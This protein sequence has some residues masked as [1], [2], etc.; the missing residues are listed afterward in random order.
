MYKRDIYTICEN[1]KI[2]NAVFLMTLKGDTSFLTAPGQFINIELDGFY[3]RR[4][5]SV[6]DW[7]KEIITIIYK[8]VGGGTQKLS[9]MHCGESLDVLTGLGN[10]FT[11]SS[12]S[13]APLVIGGGV[14]APPMYALAKQLVA[15]GKIPTVILGFASKEDVFFENEFARLG[16]PVYIATNDGSYG[17]KGFV[18][19]VIDTL[20]SYDYFYA[21]GPEAMLKAVSRATNT[22][23][24]MSFEE[25][26]GCGFGGCMG[27]SC[28]TLTGYKRICTEGPV[29]IK[30]EVLW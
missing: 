30:E 5:I 22:S 1:K 10:G 25:R 16:C 3:L 23:G 26:M 2:A 17:D 15:N 24:Q 12:T 21:C 20:A 6:C 28:K 19:D 13:K 18:T 4:P 8:V 14:G 29:L 27:C 7:D 9:L 11:L